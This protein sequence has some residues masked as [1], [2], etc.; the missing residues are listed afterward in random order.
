ML[1]Q[2]LQEKQIT[3]GKRL[4]LADRRHVTSRAGESGE[5]FARAAFA[6]PIE[7]GAERGRPALGDR[8]RDPPRMLIRRRGLWLGSAHRAASA[9]HAMVPG[10]RVSVL[11]KSAKSTP[12]DRRPWRR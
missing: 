3:D 11:S 7:V 6:V 8:T 2:P 1:E 12:Q 10:T 9:N 5:D 4:V